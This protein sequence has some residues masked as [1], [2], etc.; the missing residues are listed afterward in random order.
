MPKAIDVVD[1]FAEEAKGQVGGRR[2]PAAIGACSE[3]AAV[4]NEAGMRQAIDSGLTD[5]LAVERGLIRLSFAPGSRRS[6]PPAAAVG[7]L[8]AHGGGASQ[9]SL[10]DLSTASGA[11]TR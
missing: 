5:G 11:K 3:I 7:D 2:L 8:S 9:M 10:T 4:I 1:V 6:C